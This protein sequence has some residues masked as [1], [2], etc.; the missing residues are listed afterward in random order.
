M[1]PA[2]WLTDLEVAYRKDRYTIGIGGQDL[3]NVLP[4]PQVASIAF[5]NIRTFP[6]NAP[7][8]FNGRFLYARMTY[9]F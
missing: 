9:R 4:D 2:K 8:G 5:N 3:F 1:F 6:R 7:F